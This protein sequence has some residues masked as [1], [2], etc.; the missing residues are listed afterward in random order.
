MTS[1][2]VAYHPHLHIIII[3]CRPTGT[4]TSFAYHRASRPTLGGLHI[5]VGPFW[6]VHHIFMLPSFSCHRLP[7][8][9]LQTHRVIHH[10]CILPSFSML[11]CLYTI[12]GLLWGV[13]HVFILPSFAYYHS[14][15]QDDR[16]H[17]VNTQIDGLGEQQC[18][19]SVRDFWQPCVSACILFPCEH[20]L[21][22]TNNK[23]FAH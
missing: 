17:T 9:L 7:I 3:L 19:D 22:F 5:I 6:A 20:N 12:V 11:S 8:T 10:V 13:H 21:E 14:P 18:T 4:F 2:I 1:V 15:D 23:L 16:L